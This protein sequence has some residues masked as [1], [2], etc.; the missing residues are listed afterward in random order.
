MKILANK[1]IYYVSCPSDS[2]VLIAMDL[3]LTESNQLTWLDTV[4]ERSMAVEKVLEN[5]ENS[6][7]FERSREEGGGIY[8]FVPMTLAI[9][10]EKVK[11]HLLS[12]GDFKSEEELI[13]AF[14]KTRSN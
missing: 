1:I 2:T 11:E 8:T 3:M 7:V 5:T 14:E 9:Y 4:K 10:N 6:F 12:P 13:E